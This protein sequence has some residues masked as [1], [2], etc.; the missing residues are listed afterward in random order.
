[1]CG[2]RAG[3]CWDLE[4]MVR[5][6]MKNKKSW[7]AWIGIIVVCLCIFGV[8]GKLLWSWTFI[9]IFTALEKAFYPELNVQ[10]VSN[11]GKVNEGYFRADGE[12]ILIRGEWQYD[13]AAIQEF[14]RYRLYDKQGNLIADLG[15]AT[16]GYSTSNNVVLVALNK[17]PE[18]FKSSWKLSFW[19]WDGKLIQD[20]GAFFG[21]PPILIFNPD[22][23]KFITFRNYDSW[24][25]ATSRQE[26]L[27]TADGQEIATLSAL[28]GQKIEGISF[29]PDGKII[30]AYGLNTVRRW[31]ENGNLLET[32][33]I[34]VSDHLLPEIHFSP[35][36][37]QWAVSDE[38]DHHS[39]I[40]TGDW[41]LVHTLK[42]TQVL[43]YSP[44][45]RY[46]IGNQP[47]F[48]GYNFH[49][50]LFDTQNNFAPK[51]IAT[52]NTLADLRFAPDGQHFITFG[53]TDGWAF[54][55][56]VF[57]CDGGKASLWDKDGNFVADLKG[58]A[59]VT[60]VAFVP[61]SDKIITA[62]CD[63][64][65]RQLELVRTPHCLSSSLRLHDTSGATIA[66]LRDDIGDFWISPDGK[67][68]ITADGK[69]LITNT[70]QSGDNG[71]IWR[72]GP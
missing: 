59:K 37:K 16:A 31:D 14:S 13:Q 67:S 36:G 33:S 8:F 49:I 2:L 58:H 54:E 48:D 57:Y 25:P 11:L 9:P 38:S 17:S 18:G 4:G 10:M 21:T 72:F 60:Q 3:D 44:D 32:F 64:Y 26:Y 62:G 46:L 20:S 55:V 6:S 29:S 66:I 12:R 1:V 52:Y 23:S 30:S 61:N 39:E 27:W 63:G 40:W 24:P 22:F 34:P 51:K 5:E 53:C 19:S 47:V 50:T 43:T 45:G 56:G 28:D 71:K 15:E 68:L 35:D 69:P 42:D 70:H 41:Q 7:G 65:V